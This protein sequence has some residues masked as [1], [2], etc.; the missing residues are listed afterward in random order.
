MDKSNKIK[1]SFE[2]VS[3]DD[4]LPNLWDN[5]SKELARTATTSESTKK[6]KDSFASIQH[7]EAVVILGQH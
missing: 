5:I 1:D 2:Q 7:N 4:S 6:I 3:I